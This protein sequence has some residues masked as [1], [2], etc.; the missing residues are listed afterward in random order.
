[1]DAKFDQETP[2]QSVVHCCQTQGHI[3][4]SQDQ[5]EVKYFEMPYG[6]KLDGK[7]P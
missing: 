6:T 1:M 2:D 4:V 5:Q 7:N 3:G